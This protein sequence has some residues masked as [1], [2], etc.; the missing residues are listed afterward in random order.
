M[1]VAAGSTVGSAVAWGL[2]ASVA[3]GSTVATGDTLGAAVAVGP[4]EALS[5]ASGDEVA[6]LESLESSRPPSRPP[7]PRR[8]AQ[9]KMSANT[10]AMRTIHH[11]LTG[12]SM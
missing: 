5:V 12:S 7:E 11:L 8:I 10:A 4:T 2:G 1:L 6:T 9:A 3:G